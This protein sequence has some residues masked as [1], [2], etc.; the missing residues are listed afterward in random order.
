MIGSLAWVRFIRVLCFIHRFT[1]LPRVWFLV[2]IIRK[3]VRKRI[4]TTQKVWFGQPRIRACFDSTYTFRFNDDPSLRP[5]AM[6]DYIGKHRE[7]LQLVSLQVKPSWTILKSTRS[8]TS[9]Y[10]FLPTQRSNQPLKPS[11]SQVWSTASFEELRFGAKLQAQVR[12]VDPK[13]L[14]QETPQM[15]RELANFIVIETIIGDNHQRGSNTHFSLA[16]FLVMLILGR[17]NMGEG[18]FLDS[19]ERAK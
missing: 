16:I 19:G 9:Y 2:Y 18:F 6:N 12:S 4:Q 14:T 3:K 17:E 10:R 5:T 11:T 8:I 15:G 13:T 1:L 7:G